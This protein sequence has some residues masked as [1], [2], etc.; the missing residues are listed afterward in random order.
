MA[1]QTPAT[2][3]PNQ[4]EN[5]QQKQPWESLGFSSFEDYQKA[6]E[7][8]VEKVRKQNAEATVLIDKQGNELGDLRKKVEAL[9]TK[10]A[11]PPGPGEGAGKANPPKSPGPGEDAGKANP[12]ESP[13]PGKD[14]GKAEATK[15][16]KELAITMTDEQRKK[17]NEELEKAPQEVASLATSDDPEC[18]LLFLQK[19]LGADVIT[20]PKR[21][22]FADLIPEKKETLSEKLARLMSQMDQTPPD[23]Y[24]VR[25]G[26]PTS[27]PNN[28]NKNRP[29]REF[30]SVMGLEGALK[31]DK[32]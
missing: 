20:K 14:A 27:R 2:G 13:G 16:L 5:T 15:K 26:S 18:R 4:G 24:A 3:A 11:D 17:V 32:T 12:P 8:E 9:G 23:P 19:T 25:R 29:M 31:K 22:F 7:A 28:E 6:Q 10:S 1:E 21:D 30:N